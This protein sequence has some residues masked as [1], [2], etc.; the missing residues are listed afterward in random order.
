VQLSK[1]AE[2]SGFERPWVGALAGLVVCGSLGL[3]GL[4]WGADIAW[5]QTRTSGT[6]A[7]GKRTS[8][9]VANFVGG[10]RAEV[11]TSCSSG[12]LDAD[13]WATSKC[14]TEIRFADGSRIFMSFDSKHDE[15][16]LNAKASGTFKGGAGRFAGITGMATGTGLTGKMDWV[17]SYTLPSK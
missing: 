3:P 17:G 5:S 13:G 14:D 9:G 6:M 7:T 8:E 2:M 10:E 12:P 11:S 16:T 15:K 1:E 4:A